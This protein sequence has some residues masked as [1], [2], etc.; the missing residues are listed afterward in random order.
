MKHPLSDNGVLISGVLISGVWRVVSGVWRVE[1][2]VWREPHHVPCPCLGTELQKW[3]KSVKPTW[4]MVGAHI[5]G[6]GKMKLFFVRQAFFNG[7]IA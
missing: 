7:S 3:A 5:L 2:G 1:S 6:R 4:Q